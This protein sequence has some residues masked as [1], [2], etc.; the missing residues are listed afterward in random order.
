MQPPCK[1]CE[2]RKLKC[3]STCEKYKSYSEIMVVARQ[4]RYAEGLSRTAHYDAIEKT[5]KRSR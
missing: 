3:H 2:N 5:I 4:K 1:D